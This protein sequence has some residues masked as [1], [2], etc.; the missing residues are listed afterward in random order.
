MTPERTEAILRGVIASLGV[1]IEELE[2]IDAVRPVP[3]P[4]VQHLLASMRQSKLSLEQL[5]GR[6]L[7]PP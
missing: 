7:P 6:S 1:F 2:V 3:T 5:I 4:A